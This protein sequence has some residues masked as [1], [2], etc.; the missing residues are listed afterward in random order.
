MLDEAGLSGE[1]TMTEEAHGTG[2]WLANDGEWYPPHLHPQSQQRSQVDSFAGSDHTSGT[3]LQEPSNATLPQSPPVV[4]SGYHPGYGFNG[5]YVGA[6]MPPPTWDSAGV[7]YNH[8]YI[9]PS[10]NGLAIASLV[11]SIVSLVGIGSILGII[12]G[13]VSKRQIDRS[14]GTQKGKGLALAGIII[15]F[16]TLALV[17]FAIAIPTFLGVRATS[18]NQ[19]VTHLPLAPIVLDQPIEGGQTAI[20]WQASS[21]SVDTTL[22]PAP[23]GVSMTI[24]SPN[25][26]EWAGVPASGVYPSI[27]LAATVAISAGSVSNG[28]GLACIT[29]SR[30]EQVDF[31]VHNSGLWQVELVTPSGGSVVDSGFS[32][33]VHPTGSNALTIACDTEPE[34]PASTH[35]AFE[36]NQTPISN[37][38]IRFSSVEWA[39]AIQLCAC[40]G[41]TTGSFSDVAYYASASASSP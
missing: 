41:P 4:P 18:S 40:F 2:W 1:P 35:V 32:S 33:V 31:I 14:A 8:S 28:I 26:A 11:L 6:G 12:F 25:Q 17:L 13:F 38:I 20:P 30:T 3:N 10:T 16:V 21:Q 7:S 34:D 27:Q 36:I 37:A 39:P 19:S 5:P 29:P 22:T 23:D 9:P 24:A 15:G